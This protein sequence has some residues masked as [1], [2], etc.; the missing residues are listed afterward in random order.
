MKS[1]R[2][3]ALTIAAFAPFGDVIAA[4]AATQ[5]FTINAGTCLRFHDLAHIDCEAEGGRAGI[6]LFQASPCELPFDVTMLERHPL[7]TQAFIPRSHAPYLV[8]VAESPSTP[9]RAFLARDGM[10]VNYR[11]GTWHHPLIALE[12]PSEFVVIDRIG[13]G[14]NCDEVMLEQR[15]QLERI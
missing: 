4:A 11:R 9:P 2:I 12:V 15:W 3:E 10:G 8:V 5:T 13:S 14:D 1:L 7:G 6:S